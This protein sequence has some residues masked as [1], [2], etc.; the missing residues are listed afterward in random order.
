MIL[1]PYR[2]ATQDS[3][4]E[5][6]GLATHISHLDFVEYTVP[7][8]QVQKLSANHNIN[9]RVHRARRGRMWDGMKESQVAVAHIKTQL[10]RNLEAKRSAFELVTWCI[11]RLG[12]NDDRDE[13]GG[14]DGTNDHQDDDAE[15]DVDMMD[16]EAIVYAADN[17]IGIPETLLFNEQ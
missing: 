12:L 5:K 10:S 17:P 4:G 1:S 11:V 9:K 2:T 7:L 13:Q 16:I 6:F 3:S 14:H 8:Y 15:E